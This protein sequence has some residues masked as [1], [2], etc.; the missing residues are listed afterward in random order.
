M[1]MIHANLKRARVGEVNGMLIQASGVDIP[2][3]GQV[4]SEQMSKRGP[5]RSSCL[6]EVLC[7]DGSCQLE[8]S[9]SSR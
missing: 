4:F 2:S 1:E 5:R 9:Q 8:K 3:E 6:K 7:R